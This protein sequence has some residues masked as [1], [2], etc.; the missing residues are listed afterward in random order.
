LKMAD[1]SGNDASSSTSNPQDD[2]TSRHPDSDSRLQ[3]EPGHEEEENPDQLPE[4]TP[5]D[6]SK[7]MDGTE[8]EGL[9]MVDPRVIED[10]LKGEQM[11]LTNHFEEARELFQRHAR[12]SVYH[13][14]ALGMILGVKC[15]LSME[16]KDQQAAYEALTHVLQLAKRYRKRDLMFP[17]LADGTDRVASLNKEQLHAE[18]IYAEATIVRGKRCHLQSSPPLFLPHQK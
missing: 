13:A 17:L 10:V 15:I 3:H 7:A 16:K 18:L 12:H 9:S 2:P 11:F 5:L 14:M 6:P 8:F 4:E 1:T